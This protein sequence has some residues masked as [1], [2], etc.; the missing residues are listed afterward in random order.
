VAR[1]DL[2]VVGVFVT[3]RHALHIYAVSTDGLD[4]GLEIGSGGHH[5]D[6]FRCLGDR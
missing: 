2:E 3:G 6:L 1:S 5:A 4:E